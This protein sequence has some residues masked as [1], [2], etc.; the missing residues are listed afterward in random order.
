M[1]VWSTHSVFHA[2]LSSKCSAILPCSWVGCSYFRNNQV[3]PEQGWD[4]LVRGLEQPGACFPPGLR[5][6][7]GFS[8]V[9]LT[10]QGFHELLFWRLQVVPKQRVHGHY[11]PRGAEPTLGAVTL[12]DPLLEGHMHGHRTFCCQHPSPRSTSSTSLITVEPSPWAVH[13]SPCPEVAS[14][15]FPMLL[16]W[17]WLRSHILSLQSSLKLRCSDTSNWE[18]AMY[19]FYSQ[20]E[21]SPEISNYKE[22]MFKFQKQFSWIPLYLAQLNSDHGAASFWLSWRLFTVG[23]TLLSS[24]NS[25][26]LA[27][28]EFYFQRSKILV[29]VLDPCYLKYSLWTNGVR[30]TWELAGGAKPQASAPN[31]LTQNLYF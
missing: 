15:P 9:R 6:V 3:A 17:K 28:K 18:L 20:S 21:N 4:D 11:H 27:Q 12:G 29:C 31:L 14:I 2:G 19:S 24:L 10:P 25:F 13:P 5:Q 1:G 26:V 22:N 23:L 16:W 7:V 30:P 8:H